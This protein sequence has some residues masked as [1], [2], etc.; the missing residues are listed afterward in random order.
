MVWA[1]SYG[2]KRPQ[3]RRGTMPLPWKIPWKVWWRH[4]W[5]WEGARCWKAVP[6]SKN[7]FSST[8]CRSKNSHNNRS[9]ST[10]R[11]HSKESLGDVSTCKQFAVWWQRVWSSCKW[12]LPTFPPC[13]E[14]LAKKKGAVDW[15]WLATSMLTGV[16]SLRKTYNRDGLQKQAYEEVSLFWKRLS[17]NFLPL[18]CAHG[19]RSRWKSDCA[20]I[21]L[22]GFNIDVFIG[23]SRP[24]S[25]DGS[26]IPSV[27]CG[28]W[29]CE[30][31]PPPNLAW[32]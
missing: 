9:L 23:V 21:A 13:V 14:F 31:Y 20:Q 25:F 4:G 19:S 18:R 12:F 11:S 26:P 30:K 8:P 17:S 16:G 5:Q 27:L 22:E 24:S 29:E 15:E 6:T 28:N 10:W 7:V 32:R 1:S 2:T 3:Q